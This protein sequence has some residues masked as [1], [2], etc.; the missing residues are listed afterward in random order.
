MMLDYDD[1]RIRALVAAGAFGDP[2]R[3]AHPRR[4]PPGRGAPG[5][6]APHGAEMAAGEGAEGGEV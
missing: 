2:T 5:G 4:V 3:A 1:E 6:R